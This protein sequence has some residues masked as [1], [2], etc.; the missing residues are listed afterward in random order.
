MK[1]ATASFQ[2]KYYIELREIDRE[3]GI[4]HTPLLVSADR[5]EIEMMSRVS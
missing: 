2:K 1:L 4:M 3:L 5:E